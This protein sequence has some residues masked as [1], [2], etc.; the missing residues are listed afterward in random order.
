[1][2]T[3]LCAVCLG[4][5]AV[6]AADE[7]WIQFR[8]PH[9]DGTT[10]E[11]GL[12]VKI[13]EDSPEIVWKTPIPGRAWASPVIWEKQIWLSNAPELRAES[14][15]EK[16]DP[17][18]ELSAVCVDLDTGKIVRNIKLFD[19]DTLQITHD[20][21]SYASPTPYLEEGRGY[22]HFGAYGTACVDT[23]TGQKLWERRD[24]QCDHFRGPGSSPVVYGDL[25]Y[26]SFDGID[27]QFFVA[28][29]KF[30]GETVWRKTRDVDYGTDNG[31]AKKA[32]S[33][34]VLI[35]VDG[36]DL[37]VS[38]FA[39]ATIAYHPQTGDEVWR[40]LHGGT[41]AAARPLYGGGLLYINAADGPNPLL[42]IPPNGEGD[43]TK[44]IVWRT[45]K[46]VPKRPSQLLIGDL[47]FMV[48]DTGVAVCLD[49]KTG[50][51]IWAA[52]LPGDYWSS[53]LFADGLIYCC[54]QQGDVP[55]FKA[56]RKFELIAEN[57]LDDGFVASPAVAGKS[58][59]LRG[60]RHLYR[61]ERRPEASR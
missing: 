52:R 6:A 45:A 24:L 2:R 51:E 16:L 38:P 31:D 29:D 35:E 13:S 59:I 21:N 61:I 26:L 8:G 58:L 14:A 60:K 18:V 34:P 49:A 50:K 9:A 30:T 19:V 33:T 25:L 10:T 48:N 36:R 17:P 46:A 11:T 20:T 55:V 12:P 4:F 27:V 37:L 41:N 28:L 7:T 56:S 57:K 3:L 47:L 54:S 39:A 53:P 5:A 22:F 1:M 32:F 40:I 23:S 15:G 44:N 42:A 43:I